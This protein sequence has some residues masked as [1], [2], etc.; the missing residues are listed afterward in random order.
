MT[1]NLQ[2][3]FKPAPIPPRMISFWVYFYA[4]IMSWEEPYPTSL[5][6]F[7]QAYELR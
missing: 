5:E 1:I 2:D 4:G 7:A 6:S 3:Q